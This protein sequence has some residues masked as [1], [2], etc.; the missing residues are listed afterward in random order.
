MKKVSRKLVASL[1]IVPLTV[2]SFSHES[3]A[4]VFNPKTLRTVQICNTIMNMQDADPDNPELRIGRRECN[5]RAYNVQLCTA[6][7]SNYAACW[8]EKYTQVVNVST[9]EL[10]KIIANNQ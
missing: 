7:G 3:N 1:F 9:E 10:E 2:V 4:Q 8:D 6:S 5:V